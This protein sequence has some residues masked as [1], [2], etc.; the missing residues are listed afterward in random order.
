MGHRQ[1]DA[2]RRRLRLA[3]RSAR[4]A[5]AVPASSATTPDDTVSHAAMPY[6]NARGANAALQGRRSRGTKGH[7]RTLLRRHRRSVHAGSEIA[8]SPHGRQHYVVCTPLASAVERSLDSL[9]AGRQGHAH[10]EPGEGGR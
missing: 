9:S 10:K 6:R 2:V 5:E 8:A 1:T 3:S 4:P 7:S